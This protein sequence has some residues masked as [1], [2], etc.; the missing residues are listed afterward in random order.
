VFKE[1]HN[2]MNEFIFYDIPSPKVYI[3][4]QGIGFVL[5][6]EKLTKEDI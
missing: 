2:F 1:M 6:I 3:G 5:A 4:D